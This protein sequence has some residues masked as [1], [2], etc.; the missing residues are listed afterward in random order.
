MSNTIEHQAALARMAE[1]RRYADATRRHA[2]A[3]PRRRGFYGTYSRI[4]P[5]SRKPI[6]A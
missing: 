4:R 3:Q 1:M 6:A 2:H 5:R